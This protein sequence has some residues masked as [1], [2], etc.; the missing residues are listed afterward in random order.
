M[1][2]ARV[3]SETSRNSQWKV[4][5]IDEG[6]YWHLLRPWSRIGSNVELGCLPESWIPQL[7]WSWLLLRIYGQFR[8]QERAEYAFVYQMCLHITNCVSSSWNIAVL[9][10]NDLLRP[11]SVFYQEPQPLPTGAG[12]PEITDIPQIEDPVERQLMEQNVKAH[13]IA[14]KIQQVFF[15]ARIEGLGKPFQ[16]LSSCPFTKSRFVFHNYKLCA[17][18]TSNYVGLRVAGIR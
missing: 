17:S 7:V 11:Q 16:V 12:I 5:P 10:Q 4:L 3:L 14:Y 18:C 1:C 8:R 2:N 9:P 15:Q 13:K 6:G